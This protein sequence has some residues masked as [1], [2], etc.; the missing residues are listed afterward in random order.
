MSSSTGV[1]ASAMIGAGT[2]IVDAEMPSRSRFSLIASRIAGHAADIVKGVPGA[3]ERDLKL[4]RARKKLD[5]EGQRRLAID[6]YKF[7][8]I[9]NKRRS[10]T[11]ACSMCGEY[12]AMR[13][14]SEFL[15]SEGEPDAFRCQ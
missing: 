8:D 14:V 7:A 15:N 10:K 9:R 5:W 3:L 4:S 12:C 11:E 6:P 1:T 13:L 2:M